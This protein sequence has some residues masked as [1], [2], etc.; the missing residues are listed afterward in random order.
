MATTVE[1]AFVLLDHASR[2]LRSI[3]NEALEANKALNAMGG[4]GSSSSAIRNFEN[5]ATAASKVESAVKGTSTEMKKG[6]TE[7][8]K[9]ATAAK[10]AHPHFS[11]LA[12]AV[13]GLT[14]HTKTL[15]GHLTGNGGI[16]R[17][18]TDLKN[19]VMP[20]A[21]P[22]AAAA[23]GVKGLVTALPLLPTAIAL[24]LPAIFSL[25][26]ALGA[27][28]SSL[29]FAVGGGV[30]LG[31]GLFGSMAVGIGSIVAVAKPAITALGNYKK[32]QDALNKAI[33][34]GN[35]NEIKKQQQALDNLSK[36]N[37]GVRQL[38]NNLAAFKAEWNK[39]VAPGKS[40][41]LKL[42]ADSI[43]TLRKLT[44]ALA[45]EVNANSGA[46]ESGFRKIMSPFLESKVFT[47]FIAEL[48][49]IFRRNLPGL[50]AGFVNILT[51][52]ASVLKVLDPQLSR[53]GSS[54]ESF[55][56]KFAKWAASARGK[57]DIQ[58][59][60][61]AFSE[62][63]R[64]L[65]EVA[66]LIGVISGGGASKG[67][68]VITTWAD[69]VTRLADKLS[70]TKGQA[71]LSNYFERTLAEAGRVWNTL[72]DL[73]KQV[74]VLYQVLKPM[75]A[76][77]MKIIQ[78]L[79]PGALTVL[80]SLYLALKVGAGAKAGVAARHSP[81]RERGGAGAGAAAKGAITNALG[82][83][84]GGAAGG[85]GVAGAS[86]LTGATFGEGS[87]LTTVTGAAALSPAALA[88]LPV[89]LAGRW[90]S[91]RQVVPQGPVSQARAEPAHPRSAPPRTAVVLLPPRT[92]TRVRGTWGPTG[93]PRPR[94]AW[95]AIQV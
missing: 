93:P 53:T 1:A 95:V 77:V 91:A 27:L 37:P 69:A 65:K 46:I 64:L 28:A 41:F 7:I 90:P 44:P 3:R 45:K 20:L 78:I 31:G 71:G 42:A 74:T 22:F 92:R 62:W 26:G 23:G 60:G 12:A 16:A 67:T 35:A 80:G 51:G 75:S 70:S 24:V 87:T 79:P 15:L 30:L 49:E 50:M 14:T 61:H 10:N 11:R 47:G 38:A 17:Y 81:G 9:G 86:A 39:A 88:A 40:N 25:I 32:A 6:A 5:M 18:L 52:L 19:A 54:F 85:A 76:V 66:R 2:P 4:S 58:N 34:S 21:P 82:G 55:T 63:V 48:G 94:G 73:I 83:A 59:M 89:V 84:A 33:Q 72:K 13:L 36:A 57:T 43:G 56:G 68:S 8:D 29:T